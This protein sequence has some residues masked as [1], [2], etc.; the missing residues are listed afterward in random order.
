MIIKSQNIRGEIKIPEHF[1]DFRGYDKK[2]E[3][4]GKTD[5]FIIKFAS[6]VGQSSA[7]LFERMKNYEKWEGNR[8]FCG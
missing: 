4:S 6:P 2:A 3:T 7:K 1:T 5:S 8:N